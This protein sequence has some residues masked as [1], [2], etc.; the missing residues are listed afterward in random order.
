MRHITR[1][2]LVALLTTLATP[3]LTAGEVKIV[4]AKASRTSEDSYRFDVSL[5]HADTG[6]KHYANQW[7]VFT[8]DGQLLGARTL[9]HPHVNEQPFSRSLDNV[10]VPKGETSVI[11][12]ANDNVHGMSPQKFRLILP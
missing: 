12:R 8:N 10:K 7:Q 4:D 9:Y 3:N 6:W 1:P 2:G 5:Q 11:I